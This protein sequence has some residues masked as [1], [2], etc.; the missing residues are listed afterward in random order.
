MADETTVTWNLIQRKYFYS[1]FSVMIL[2]LF[3]KS[4][5]VKKKSAE[6][7]ELWS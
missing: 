7:V 6:N 3:E 1:S 4:T 5:K 2:D